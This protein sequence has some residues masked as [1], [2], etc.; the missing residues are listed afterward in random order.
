MTLAC[1]WFQREGEEV[2]ETFC[3]G[4][5]KEGGGILYFEFH[6]LPLGVWVASFVAS[7]VLV[8]GEGSFEQPGPILSTAEE[9][10]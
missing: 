8:P 3:W 1:V 4:H 6:P 5:Q 7:H 2:D 9:S 10:Q